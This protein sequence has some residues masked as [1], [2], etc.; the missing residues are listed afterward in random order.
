MGQRKRRAEGSPASVRHGVLR[1]SNSWLNAAK[2]LLTA[3][4]VVALSGI[5]VA[6]YAVW[7][8]VQD[9]IGRA[10]V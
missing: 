8:L 4:I 5:S 3:V 7:G 10:H 9:E 2:V 6:A 1:R